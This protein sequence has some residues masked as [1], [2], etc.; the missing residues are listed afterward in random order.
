MFDITSPESLL[1]LEPFIE[2]MRRIKDCNEHQIPCL[3]VGNK[4]D[5]DP[6]KRKVTFEEAKAWAHKHGMPYMEIS[7]CKQTNVNQVFETAT[8]QVLQ[9][10]LYQYN[11]VH[12]N[13]SKQP[14]SSKCTVM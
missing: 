2:L 5:L 7:A 10:R 8:I 4:I 3:L 14:L 12:R 11:Q 9:H 6:S 1:E 13:N